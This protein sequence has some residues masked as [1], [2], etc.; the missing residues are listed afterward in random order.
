MPLTI[1][2]NTQNQQHSENQPSTMQGVAIPSASFQSISSV[3]QL[4]PLQP[5]Q[6][7]RPPQPPQHLRPPVQ[8]LLQ[9]DP[10]MSVQSGGQV[11]P[12]QMLQQPQASMQTYYQNH[13][14]EFSQAQQQVR[15][16]DYPQQSADAQLLE[17]E[18]D[19]GISLHEFFKS[20]EAIQVFVLHIT[21]I[22]QVVISLGWL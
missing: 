16:V 12:M 7:P 9:M 5:P 3:T 4:Q 6:L 22:I 20:P 17:Q 11:H 18:Q 10:G 13:P 14:Q 2:G 21:F 19:P 8:A 15:Q 1:Y